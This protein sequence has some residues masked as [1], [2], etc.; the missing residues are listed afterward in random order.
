MMSEYSVMRLRSLACHLPERIP[1]VCIGEGA[2]HHH[3]A[4]AALGLVSLRGYVPVR[5]GME[6][7][8]SAIFG[9]SAS[10]EAYLG[11]KIVVFSSGRTSLKDVA[12]LQDIAPVLRAKIVELPD[13]AVVCTGSEHVKALGVAHAKGASVYEVM[14]SERMER[15]PRGE[16]DM[17]R[18]IQEINL[19]DTAD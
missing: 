5:L 1:I 12:T 15:T 4:S 19:I 17:T 13:G 11:D 18:S 7:R 9:T 10:V 6:V 3:V 8:I 14:I 16:S 2:R